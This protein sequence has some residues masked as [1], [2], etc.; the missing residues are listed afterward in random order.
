[1]RKQKGLVLLGES[2]SALVLE[3]LLHTREH[4]KER[5]KALED[6]IAACAQPWV[7]MRQLNTVQLTK[8]FARLVQNVLLLGGI[9]RAK[10]QIHHPAEFLSGKRFP[11][12]DFQNPG[13]VAFGQP[14]Q[15]SRRGG[16]Q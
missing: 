12:D 5:A 15:V 14:D 11:A 7:S 3:P 10:Q 13:L 2:A 8:R 9:G 4:G 1:M 6:Q 16:R